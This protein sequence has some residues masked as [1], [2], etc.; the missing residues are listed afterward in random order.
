MLFAAVH[1]VAPHPLLRC[2]L[3]PTCSQSKLIHVVSAGGF[4][5]K[6]EHDAFCSP[7]MDCVISNVMDQS[8]NGNHL[9][10]RHKLVNASRHIVTVG[11]TDT[12][13]YGMWFDAGF[14]MH[15]DQTKGVATGN[16]PESMYAVMSGKHYNGKCCFDYGNSE[17]NDRDDGAGAMEAIYFGNAHWR[18]NTGA[19]PDGPW[20]GADL[21]SGMY[22][23]GGNVTVVNNQSEPLTSEFVSLGL[24][25]RADGFTIMGGDAT[26]GTFTTMYDGPRPFQP[27]PN[28][29]HSLEQGTMP[30]QLAPCAHGAANQTFRVFHELNSTSIAATVYGSDVCLDIQQF[31]TKAGSP[32]YAWPCGKNGVK[33]NEFWTIKEETIASLQPHTPFCFGAAV[34][35][36]AALADCSSSDAQFNIGFTATTKGTMVHKASGQCITAVGRQPPPHHGGGYQPMKKQGAIILATG[37][38]NSNGAEGNFY[39]GFMATGYASAATDAAV[40][41][42][43]VAVG[44]KNTERWW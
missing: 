2:L 19:G 26:V 23:G 3:P 31:R 32:V 40:Q 24:K 18:G 5:D 44:Y 15:V 12:P 17:T 43:I 22:Y 34:N 36:T 6:A 14:G 7:A 39:E 4:A 41:A 8:P 37:G 30:L 27:M 42:N 16:D 25:G 10:Q 29:S 13:V 28:E 38:D 35:G 1:A 21:E 20:A 33:S 11:S 9:G